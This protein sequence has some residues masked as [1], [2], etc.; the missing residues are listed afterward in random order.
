MKK[1]IFVIPLVVL[2]ALGVMMSTRGAQ[3]QA[4]GQAPLTIG[5]YAP[6][7]EFGTAQA[8]LSYAQGLAKAIE[9][10]SGVKTTAQ[11]FAS[12]GQLKKANVDFAIIDG[13][14]YATNSSFKLLANAEVGG[15]TTRAWALYS[16]IGPDPQSLKGKKL[17]FVQTGCNDTG[18]IDNAMLESEAAGLFA[19]QVGKPDLTAAVA[20]VASYKG[21]QA[22]FAPVGAQKGLTKVFD[23]GNVPN[24]AFVQLNSKI[25]AN[26]SQ[27]VAGAV[28][29]FG[30][31]GAISGWAAASR[32]PY[33]ALAGRLGAVVKRMVP[34]DPQPVRLDSSDV[35]VEPATLS[36]TALTG[37][38][39]HYEVPPSR[40]E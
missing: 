14:C 39:G 31:S 28:V 18:F 38:H 33:E 20:E 40:L 24:P 29:G 37:V 9:Q 6:S 21:A 10:A 23:T 7:V 35:L 12:L 30:G 22:V 3:S 8:R 16:S 1:I 25:P 26:V 13:L 27:Q 32:G 2:A 4:A 36:D 15:G 19:S 11:A 17:A 34:A 5:I